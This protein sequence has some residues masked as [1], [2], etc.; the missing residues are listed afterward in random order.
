MRVKLTTDVLFQLSECL[1]VAGLAMDKAAIT[2][3]RGF[4]TAFTTKEL[5]LKSVRGEFC[6]GADRSLEHPVIIATVCDGDGLELGTCATQANEKG[7]W[8]SPKFALNPERRAYDVL[9]AVYTKG[10]SLPA[11]LQA[12]MKLVVDELASKLGGPKVK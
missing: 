10:M 9:K 1:H 7:G 2:A 8:T 4:P 5:S 11:N 3:I 6:P 12:E